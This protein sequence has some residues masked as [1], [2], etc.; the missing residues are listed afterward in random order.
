GSTQL[1]GLP[2][3]D[4]AV[5]QDG[6]GRVGLRWRFAGTMP[7]PITLRVTTSQVLSA[8][9]E[10]VTVARART[11]ADRAAER[12]S[13]LTSGPGI[14]LVAPADGTVLPSDR[15]YIGAK[16]EPGA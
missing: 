9:P 8:G 12:R 3:S 14:E 11:E 4:P 5:G 13:S 16:G 6:A 15:V 2:A 1:R 7:A 10:K